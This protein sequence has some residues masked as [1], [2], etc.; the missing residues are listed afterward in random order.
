MGPTDRRSLPYFGEQSVIFPSGDGTLRD[1]DNFA[2]Q[3]PQRPRRT[4]VPD[5]SSHSFRKTVA[6]LIDDAGLS[7]RIGADHLGHP[8]KCR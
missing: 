6:T 7:A 8:P 1:P 5:I 4:G 3:W 2:G